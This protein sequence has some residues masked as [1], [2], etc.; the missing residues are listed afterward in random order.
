MK[1]K[2]LRVIQI[3]FLATTLLIFGFA[4]YKTVRYVRSA[5]TFEVKALAVTGVNGPLRRVS[6]GEIVGQAEFE[7]GT[8][9]FRVDLEA[10][11]ERIERLRWVRHAVVQRVL[12][13]Q[14][15]I[16]V[17]EREPIG[18][19]RIRGEIYQ[20][21]EDAVILNLDA[22][23]NASFPILDGLRANAVETNRKKVALYRRVLE[24]LGQTELSQI[25]INDAA[26]VSVVSAS[27]P[28]VVSLGTT[29]FHNRWIRYLQLKTQIQQQYPQATKIDLRFKNQVIVRMKDDEGSGEQVIWDGAKKS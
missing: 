9:V 2:L 20:F 4:A 13:D 22:A 28:L 15:I 10:M 27:D 29:E 8:N 25:S 3:L 17:V 6:E 19:G 11:R 5:P 21:D 14:I 23:A 26:E 18:L 1:G 24:E 12:P 7:V 16:K